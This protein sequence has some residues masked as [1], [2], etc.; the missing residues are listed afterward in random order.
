LVTIDQI[1]QFYVLEDCCHHMCLPWELK[2]Q[3][4]GLIGHAFHYFSSAYV[5][6]SCVRIK[7]FEYWCCCPWVKIWPLTLW[8]WKVCFQMRDKIVISIQP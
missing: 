8:Y 6:F 1:K 3:N 7:F 2:S 4:L 5:W